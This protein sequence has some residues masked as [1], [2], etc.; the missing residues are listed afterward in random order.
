MTVRQALLDGMVEAA[1]DAGREI[2]A[3]FDSNFDV[4]RKADASPVTSADTAA[5]LVIL[6]ALAKLAPAAP[7]VAEEQAAAGRVPKL[8]G[9]PFFLVDPLDGTKEF[10][11]RGDDFTVNLALVEDKTPSLGVVYA[12]ARGRLYAGDAAQGAAWA[13]SADART[14][15]A[16]TRRAIRVR[17]APARIVAVASRSHNTPATDA[18]LAQYEIAE[19]VSVGSS[20]KFALVAEGEADLYPRLTPTS[21][22]DTAAGH[23]LLLAAGGRVFAADGGAL[24]YAKPGFLNSGFVAVGTL[25]PLPLA[26]FLAR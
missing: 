6:A 26:P 11:R 22:W 1:L 18:Y 2:M 3:V 14:R 4:L 8:D 9:A 5:E 12:P 20:L 13:S 19:R 7:V 24:R 16:G 17:E 25:N 23:A 15:S 21:E 10:V